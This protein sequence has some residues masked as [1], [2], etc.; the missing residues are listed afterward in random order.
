MALPSVH[1][2]AGMTTSMVVGGL[3]LFF[4]RRRALIYLP[5]VATA[6]GLMALVPDAIAW[7]RGAH[8]DSPVM[9][10]FFFHSLIR[11][12]RGLQAPEAGAAA[13][14][15]VAALYLGVLL[16]YVAYIRRRLRLEPYAV[17]ALEHMGKQMV[18]SHTA[19]VLAAL[20]PACIL[21]A[22]ASWLART[23]S[24]GRAE[25]PDH[26]AEASSPWSRLIHR[27]MHVYRPERLGLAHG[28]PWTRGEWLAGDLAIVPAD[29]AAE[30]L[31]H[32]QANGCDFVVV[33]REWHDAPGRILRG[34]LPTPAPTLL[35]GVRWSSAAG[36]LL[37]VSHADPSRH[38]S[39]LTTGEATPTPHE[40]LPLLFASGA[41][42][43]GS[44]P[45]LGPSPAD[46][47]GLRECRRDQGYT[48]RWSPNVARLGG[49]WDRLLD[50]GFR[51]TGASAASGFRSA[52]TH[53]WP[54]EAARTHV[55]CPGREAADVLAGLR[56]GCAW[57]EE[58]GIVRALD[59]TLAAPHLIR[60][61]R[62]G[63]VVAVPPGAEITV[64]L[65]LD[66]PRR[67]RVGNAIQALDDVEFIS[68]YTGQ[69]QVMKRFDDVRPTHSGQPRHLRHMVPAVADH[70]DGLGFYI[71]ARGRRRN[72]NGT[73]HWFH[74]N[75]VYVLVRPLPPP[76]EVERPMQVA[77]ARPSRGPDAKHAPAKGTPEGPGLSPKELN[78]A[79]A[80]IG[81]PNDAPVLQIETFRK[82][83]ARHWAGA[84]H[85]YAEHRG[86]AMGDTALGLR[87]DRTT[88]LTDDARLFFRCFVADCAHLA[89]LL[90]TSASPKPYPLLRVVPDRKWVVVDLPIADGFFAPEDAPP[91]LLQP[92]ELQAIEW[93][94]MG[95]SPESR[96]RITDFAIYRHT[97]SRRRDQFRRRLEALALDLGDGLKHD[98]GSPGWRQRG[99]DTL[100]R[101]N[102]LRTQTDPMKPVPTA[103][104]LAGFENQLDS[105]AAVIRQLRCEGLMYRAFQITEPRLAVAIESPL[106]RVSTRDP[107][108]GFHERIFPHVELHAAGGE[109]ESFQLVVMALWKPLE[110]V[111]VTWAKLP[112][113]V[114]G[115][116]GGEGP[117]ATLPATAVR[118]FLVDDVVV[119]PR[120]SL[121]ADRTGPVPDRLVPFAP[122]RIEP[123][124]LRSVLV[125]LL[126]PIDLPPGSYEGTLAVRARDVKPVL[127]AVKLHRLDYA[128]DSAPLP[129]LALVQPGVG[130]S[131][132]TRRLVRRRTYAQLLQHK[133]TPMLHPVAH[134]AAGL[135][136]A[137]FCLQRGARL[138]VLH[139][140]GDQMP[141]DTEPPMVH[142]ARI[143][144][145]LR[146]AAHGR[147]GAV[148]VSFQ[149]T[150][151]A[152]MGAVKAFSALT[153]KFPDLQWIARGGGDVPRDL[154]ADYW[155]RPL[156][157]DALTLPPDEQLAIRRAR[158]IQREAWGLRTGAACYPDVNLTLANDLLAVRLLPWM[159]WRHG[160]RALLLPGAFDKDAEATGDGS[161]LYH[162]ADHT[163]LPSLR[164]VALRDGIED[165][166]ALWALWRRAGQ[167][168]QRAR[169]QSVGLLASA[170]RILNQL[171]LRTGSLQRPSRDQAG[172]AR[173]RLSLVRMVERIQAAWWQR[174]D[175]QDI[176]GLPAPPTGL[177]ATSGDRRVT[178]A[179]T[180]STDRNVAAYHVYRS[181]QPTLGYA[182]VNPFPVTVPHFEDTAVANGT[183]YYYCIR[184][185]RDPKFQGPR[186]DVA[187]AMPMPPR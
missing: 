61:A 88:R 102:A 157:T 78:R 26:A 15:L 9:D 101:I 2:A 52:A 31:E 137:E 116:G 183:R 118:T 39:R 12:A 168:R 181:T 141:S 184:S 148:L 36:D 24:P 131:A 173:S 166:H 16:A 28:L 130:G 42:D 139:D 76:R 93:R 27:R 37:A 187:H 152:R 10:V 143:A 172:L 123:G 77:A 48:E 51:I 5:L 162:G 142:A 47:L 165:Y 44:W 158:S 65:S 49:T 69:P 63:E 150:G 56:A 144:Q 128:L 115:P 147:A 180:R 43:P 160:V 62:M 32:A 177:Q 178:L 176:A 161:L 179:W 20:L 59:L 114:A 153:R 40:P 182:R 111:Q 45:F 167:L 66:I 72:P 58:G 82:K 129:V 122:F 22:A 106:R 50:Q 23:E 7:L 29:S 169:E 149:A 18:R 90:H 38:L 145:T 135:E 125:D 97:P 54:G 13:F 30:A 127:V 154:R 81:L 133:V 146:R 8:A 19:G 164:L 105:L 136:D 109:A 117:D 92:T 96:I 84:W 71:R 83:P 46:L 4:V 86:P 1:F 67:D 140:A 94:A 21:G 91:R 104:A 25:A 126:V 3:V 6:G 108:R 155:V 151:T 11:Q 103:D 134:E 132:A 119:P 156:V 34:Q 138:A 98:P 113:T 95:L 163:V 57:A 107:A 79:R 100:T 35:R 74:T 53:F 112:T 68:N 186:S 121:P 170:D 87:Y 171:H 89:I 99:S 70:N 33:A 75:P 175:R 174:V 14:Q 185:A 120:A 60:A 110:A 85:K 73:D 55:L 41:V 159:A 124:A 64:G 80:I 17:E